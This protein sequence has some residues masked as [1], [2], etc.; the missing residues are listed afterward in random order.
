[1]RGVNYKLRCRLVQVR[2]VFVGLSWY[3][4]ANGDNDLDSAATH[5]S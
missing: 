2:R 3:P 1:M 4:I 5:S